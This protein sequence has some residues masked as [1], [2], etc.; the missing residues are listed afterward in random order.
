[1][2]PKPPW[3]R[4]RLPAPGKSRDVNRLL[5][6]LT[7]HTVCQEAM[8]PNQGE[9]YG[10]GTATFLLLGPNCTRDCAFC[11][12]HALPPAPPDPDEPV[13]IAQ[14][15][16]RMG[17]HYSVLTMVTRDDLPD[18]GAGHMAEAIR[19]IRALQPQ[20]GVEVLISD[21]K[22]DPEALETVL[23]AR[24][25]VLNHNV[26]TVPRLYPQVRPQADYQQS[27]T[28]LARAAR[29]TE[30]IVTKSGMMLG[31]GETIQEVEQVMAD[32]RQ[33]GCRLLTLGQYLAPSADHFPVKRF[34]PPETFD[35][36]AAEARR[37]GFD[38]CAS[39]PYIRS[40]YRAAD[41]LTAA[42]G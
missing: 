34:V 6:D 1:M 3:L 30:E 14:A 39:G 38:A 13:K 29:N 36:L 11:A 9:C 42:R 5:S 31:L 7:L 8:C 32:L 20:T 19:A 22:G 37:M 40:S 17:L 15:V 2:Q 12:V 27:L 25:D 16:E 4:R 10:R 33:A 41:L 24:P 26:E 18:G 21:L 23:Q 28:L 35:D